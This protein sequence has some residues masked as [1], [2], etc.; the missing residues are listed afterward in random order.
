MTYDYVC[1]FILELQLHHFALSGQNDVIGSPMPPRTHMINLLITVY[2]LIQD[3]PQPYIIIMQPIPPKHILIQTQPVSHPLF[4]R[5]GCLFIFHAMYIHVCE[6][7]FGPLV[8]TFD[9]KL[10]YF[11][12]NRRLTKFR[13]KPVSQLLFAD[14]LF[15]AIGY[16]GLTSIAVLDQHG[17][18]WQRAT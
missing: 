18:R 3:S 6:N 16:Y 10:L 7:K 1:V 13:T 12:V 14:G 8:P 2:I 15:C 4:I 17:N 5:F 9:L 11:V